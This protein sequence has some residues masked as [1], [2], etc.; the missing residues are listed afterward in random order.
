MCV[1]GVY[2]RD[3][4]WKSEVEDDDAHDEVVIMGK[5]EMARV[6]LYS[7]VQG[8]TSFQIIFLYNRD[9]R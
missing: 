5:L 6:Q 1:T 4:M 3:E 8:L 2:A 7:T 9:R